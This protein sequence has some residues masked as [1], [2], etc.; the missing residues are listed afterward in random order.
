ME[1]AAIVA[2]SQNGVIGVDNKLPWHLPADLKYFKQLTTNHTIIMGRKTYESI[3]KPLPNRKNIVISRQEEYK[4]TGCDVVGN[5]QEALTLAKTFQ[6]EKVFIIGG[7]EIYKLALPFCTHLYITYVHTEILNGDAFFAIENNE[8]LEMTV[9]RHEI[10]EKNS[11][12]MDFAS[13]KRI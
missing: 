11:L 12:V 4:V 9:K 5:I 3:G 7:A 8:W 1:I 10:D 13:Y 2:V 6:T